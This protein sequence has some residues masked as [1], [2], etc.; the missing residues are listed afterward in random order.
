MMS[1]SCNVRWETL[2]KK[3]YSRLR[4]SATKCMAKM[5]VLLEVNEYFATQSISVRTLH[6][7]WSSPLQ[8]AIGRVG[9]VT[10]AQAPYYTRRKWSIHGGGAKTVGLLPNNFVHCL[11]HLR[12]EMCTERMAGIVHGLDATTNG[13]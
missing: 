2:A 5:D 8:M 10:D 3:Q 7:P 4:K 11:L 1:D 12:H 13:H 9:M 6:R